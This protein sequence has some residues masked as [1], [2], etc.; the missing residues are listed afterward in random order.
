MI[1]QSGGSGADGCCRFSYIVG[2]CASD[3]A[4]G[5]AVLSFL[6]S[7]LL[8]VF[9]AGAARAP[10]P[11]SPAAPTGAEAAA[12]ACGGG[13]RTTTDNNR[14]NRSTNCTIDEAGGGGAPASSPLTGPFLAT[15]SDFLGYGRRV[16]GSGV[17]RGFGAAFEGFWGCF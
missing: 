15:L 4:D 7:R 6:A 17:L 2:A 1:R 5:R 13:N 8:P 11:R 16:I 10:L 3:I 14:P 9:L 12:G